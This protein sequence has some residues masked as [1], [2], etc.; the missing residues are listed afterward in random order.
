MS[1]L[2]EAVASTAHFGESKRL[3]RCARWQTII[4]IVRYGAGADGDGS[5]GGDGCARREECHR[6]G[7]VR[8]D[9]KLRIVR[10][11]INED[12]LRTFAALPHNTPIDG[13][14]CT[15]DVAHWSASMPGSSRNFQLE[16]HHM[17]GLE[18]MQMRI[19]QSLSVMLAM[20]CHSIREG[21]SQRMRLYDLTCLPQTFG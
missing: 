5:G 21:Q 4:E 12:K 13:S 16:H 14:G 18:T 6:L 2:F 1:N 10:I 17:R 7:G 11:K 20:A 19:A 9:V 8:Q 15:R 3:V